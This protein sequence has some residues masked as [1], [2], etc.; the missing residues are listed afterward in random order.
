VPIIKD[1]CVEETTR[2]LP[3]FLFVQN[4]NFAGSN[5]LFKLKYIGSRYI[6]FIEYMVFKSFVHL[7]IQPTF[8][9]LKCNLCTNLFYV[10]GEYGLNNRVVHSGRERFYNEYAPKETD[11]NKLLMK[12]TVDITKKNDD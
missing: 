3:L 12:C 11:G 8:F 6:L 9:S 2:P 7:A 1:T 10:Q 4:E 5:F